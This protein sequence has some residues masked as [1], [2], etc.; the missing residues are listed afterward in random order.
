MSNNN[1]YLHFKKIQKT[2]EWTT[3]TIKRRGICPTE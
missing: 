1:V 3:E 2:E